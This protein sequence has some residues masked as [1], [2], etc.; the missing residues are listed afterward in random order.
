MSMKGSTFVIATIG[1]VILG[2]IA[3]S[4]LTVASGAQSGG[5]SN[6]AWLYTTDNAGELARYADAVVVARLAVT[7]PGRVAFSSNGESSL[8]FEL[9]DFL[10]VDAIKGKLGATITVERVS[11][12]QNREPLLFD[13]DGGPYQLGQNVLLFLKKQ[14]DSPFF[15]VVNDEARYTIGR[16]G[17]LHSRVERPL[18]A[19]LEG[20]TLGQVRE[21][22]LQAIRH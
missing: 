22:L 14:K 20:K 13:H 5:R 3:G 18:A 11:S 6:T 1:V 2:W 4:A 9:N 16:G 21:L 19:S 15:Y 12:I 7:Y 17:R 10:V 8:A